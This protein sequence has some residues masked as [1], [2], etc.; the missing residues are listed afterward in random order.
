M[1]RKIKLSASIMCA[2]LLNLEEDLEILGQKQIDYLHFDIMDG[3]FV[4]GVGLG[5][6]LLEQLTRKQSI[7][8]ETHLMVTDPERYIDEL[9]QA[10]TA[11]ISFHYETGKDISHILQEIK[12][13]KIGAGL[14]LNP[15]TKV[16]VLEPYLDLLDTVLLMAY[17]PGIRNQ[18][19]SPNFGEKVQ[20]LMELLSKHE[21][22]N[23][24]IAVDGGLTEELIAIYRRCGANF[25]ILG[26]SVLFKPATHLDEQI[27]RLRSILDGRLEHG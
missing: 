1:N 18:V 10:G 22:Q 24:D 20:N 23:I 5:I 2:N 9:S 25:F 15:G 13:R 27:D 8:V 6:F 11:L 21:K 19:A 12:N 16:A 4:P 3:H 14:A 7:P 26:S 17:A